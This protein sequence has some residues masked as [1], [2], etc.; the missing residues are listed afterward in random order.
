MKTKFLYLLLL[1]VPLLAYSRS[2]PILILDVRPKIGDHRDEDN[3][4]NAARENF[5]EHYLPFMDTY[6]PISPISF[7]LKTLDG[8][9]VKSH[10]SNVLVVNMNNWTLL[11]QEIKSIAIHTHY[12]RLYGFTHYDIRPVS[13]A[14]STKKFEEWLTW[15]ERW[16]KVTN[17]VLN[18]N[19]FSLGLATNKLNDNFPNKVSQDTFESALESEFE[20]VDRPSTGDL[21]T[22]HSED[23][24]LLHVATFI[25]VSQT[26]TNQ[27]IFLSKNGYDKG[28]ALF[29]DKYVLINTNYPETQSIKYWHKKD[30]LLWD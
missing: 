13:M 22:L 20:E 25:G 14:E 30:H 11:P 2:G 28:R 15:I 21:M 3:L 26:N 8:W 16:S 7:E 1:L 29:I 12:L 5:M 19:C 6:V 27:S 9:I 17:T 23:G 18:A 10:N 4:Y 24:Y